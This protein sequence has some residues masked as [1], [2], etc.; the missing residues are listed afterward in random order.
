MH[1]ALEQYAVA[2]K[3]PSKAAIEAQREF[4]VYQLRRHGVP[5]GDLPRAASI[6]LEALTRTVSNDHGRWIFSVEH[7]ESR[8]EW[9]V[10]GHCCR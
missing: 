5:E 9:G 4:Y 3:L 8:S 2:S 7:S 10:D 1:A 6:V